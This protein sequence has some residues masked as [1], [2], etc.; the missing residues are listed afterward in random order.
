MLASRSFRDIEIA[1]VAL[2]TWALGGGVYGDV[3]DDESIRLIGRAHDLGVNLIDTAPIYGMGAGVDGHAER[4]VGR[5]IAGDRDRWLISTKWGR[6]LDAERFGVGDPSKTVQKFSYD[7]ALRSIEKSLERLDT[8]H[9][10]FYFAHTPLPT[11]GFDLRSLDAMDELKGEGTI[12]FRGFSLGSVDEDLPLIEPL[13][14]D[15]RLDC[16]QVTLN[17]LQQAPRERL[18]GLCAEYDLCVLARE[19]LARGFLGDAISV[20][21]D[22][23][24]TDFRSRLPRAEIARRL[25]AADCYRFLMTEG[26]SLPQ[27]AISWVLS[28]PEVSSI[29]AGPRTVVELEELVDA[30][31][32]PRFENDVMTEVDTVYAEQI[33]KGW[34]LSITVKAGS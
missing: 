22:F 1:E 26:R 6:N 20:N 11:S 24:E 12:R 9:V 10:E 13:I 8:N 23:P 29:V 4:L 34:T 28:Q 3:D 15:G 7:Q 31:L 17:L 19:S 2:G 27:A 33:A 21:T 18:L 14:R 5:A 25:G 32:L 30:A 16:I